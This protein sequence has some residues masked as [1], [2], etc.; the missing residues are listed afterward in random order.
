MM[1][2]SNSLFQIIETLAEMCQ[3]CILNQIAVFDAQAIDGINYILR[4]NLYKDCHPRMVR[5]VLVLIFVLY[6][7]LQPPSKGCPH[8]ICDRN[9]AVVIAGGWR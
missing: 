9:T 3:G 1:A 8:E 7:T 6:L 2:I 4:R 5:I